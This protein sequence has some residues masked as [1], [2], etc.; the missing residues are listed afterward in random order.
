LSGFAGVKRAASFRL[1][2]ADATRF[3][4][5][6]VAME[7]VMNRKLE[8]AITAIEEVGCCGIRNLEEIAG[9]EEQLYTAVEQVIEH[10]RNPKLRPFTLHRPQLSVVK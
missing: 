3:V 1:I 7:G 4:A 10:L 6:F 5:G 9:I 2:P 8:R